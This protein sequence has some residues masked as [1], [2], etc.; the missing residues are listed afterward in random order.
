MRIEIPDWG[1][2]LMIGA[3]GAGKSTFAR[4]HFR[5][6]EVLESDH[7]RNVVGDEVRDGRTTRDAFAVMAEITRRRL[8]AKRRAVIDATNLAPE[9]RRTFLNAARAAH[10]PMAAIVVDPGLKACLE[11]NEGRTDAR[12]RYVIE[13][14]C[15][16]MKR[17]LKGLKRDRLRQVWRLKSAAEAA[18]ATIEAKPISCNRRDLAGPFD[19]IGDIHG[20]ADELKA[21]LARLGYE[22]RDWQSPETGQAFT[23]SHPVG[24]RLVFLGDL[25]DRGPD[26]V[27]VLQLVMDAVEHGA[28]LAVPGNHDVKL[29]RALAGRDVQRGHGLAETMDQLE[30]TPEAFRERV[31]DFLNGLPSHYELDG[32]KLVAV[33]AGLTEKHHGR[34]S[35]EVRD[36][37]VYG[38]TTG[39]TGPDGL[40]RSSRRTKPR[41][42]TRRS[43]LKR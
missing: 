28:A 27:A 21:L 23:V 20:C 15:R 6:T 39:E 19:I 25:T 1:L 17:V 41:P 8:L 5:A 12:P 10:A 33:H 24:R 29:V 4:K 26:P 37:A 22:V 9:D 2:I 18:E 3:S 43:S 14:H 11:H 38:D 7:Y 35:R 36:F 31:R 34:T 30:K 40:L 13:R 16:T 32:G 42:K